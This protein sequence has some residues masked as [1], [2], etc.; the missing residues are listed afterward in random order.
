MVVGF[1]SPPKVELVGDPK[2]FTPILEAEQ[3]YLVPVLVTVPAKASAQTRPL[4]RQQVKDAI[5]AAER[6]PQKVDGA[7]IEALHAP[8][9]VP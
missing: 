7:F 5:D 2:Y 4:E 1:S 8:A 6:N 3:R 9:P